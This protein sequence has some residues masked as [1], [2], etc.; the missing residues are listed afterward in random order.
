MLIHVNGTCASAIRITAGGIVPNSA[1]ACCK[2][3]VERVEKDPIRIVWIHGDSL[4]VPVLGIV[5]LA[6]GTVSERATLRTLHK[7]P[8]RATVCCSPGTQLAAGSIAAATIAIRRDGLSLCV[9]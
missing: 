9:N 4:V 3:H 7:S 5:T 8:V 1:C 6:T 2:P